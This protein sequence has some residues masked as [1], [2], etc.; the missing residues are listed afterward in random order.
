M[1]NT[2]LLLPSGY[3]FMSATGGTSPFLLEVLD[4]DLEFATRGQGVEG[5]G[6]LPRPLT[7]TSSPRSP[8]SGS[9]AAPRPCSRRTAP[10]C[11]AW[12]PGLEHG[13]ATDPL[14]AVLEPH[15]LGPRLR[16]FRAS[17]DRFVIH[18][19]R[20]QNRLGQ[21]FNRGHIEQS[22][23]D[24]P[25]R[26]VLPSAVGAGR[27]GPRMRS[28]HRSTRGGVRTTPARSTPPKPSNFVRQIS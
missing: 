13:R 28:D 6:G 19:L 8:G 24:G 9:S 1:A 18:T 22:L 16:N 12:M 3:V 26:P 15:Q 2:A 10:T 7:R 27:P 23:D 11:R 20:R 21:Y 25:A 5:G 4:G 17:P 14:G